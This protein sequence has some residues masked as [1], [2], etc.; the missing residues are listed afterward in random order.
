MQERWNIIGME[1]V[2]KMETRRGLI[3]GHHDGIVFHSE[4]LDIGMVPEEGLTR[5]VGRDF[6][7]DYITPIVPDVSEHG[8]LFTAEDGSSTLRIGTNGDVQLFHFPPKPGSGQP[9][10]P[11]LE[12][13][14]VAESRTAPLESTPAAAPGKERQPRVEV[15]GNVGTQPRFRTTASGKDVL[16][17]SIA[18]HPDKETTLWH[19]IVAFDQRARDLRE[20][21]QKGEAL[22]IIGYPHMRVI[23]GKEGKPD[24]RVREIYMT[25]V[26]RR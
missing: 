8:I 3:V 16:E 11:P 9:L 12:E 26:K 10:S 1:D 19:N 5:I 22:G 20:T 24:K 14:P 25:G 2:I 17:F 23:P 7:L 21:L 6:R 13:A 4:D 18:E 15:F